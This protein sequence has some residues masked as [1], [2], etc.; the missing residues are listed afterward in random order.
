M[1]GE[2]DYLLRRY[3]ALRLSH[4]DLAGHIGRLTSRAVRVE[5]RLNDADAE[6]AAQAQAAAEAEATQARRR[7]ALAA[8]R[9]LIGAAIG[10]AIAGPLIAI[11]PWPHV[12]GEMV[13]N[14]ISGASGV[15][16]T[17]IGDPLTKRP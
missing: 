13:K 17:E 4:A 9:F 12:V 1:Q 7:W 2:I 14:A 6:K 10:A 5:G 8:A 3:E 15:L 16:A 11:V